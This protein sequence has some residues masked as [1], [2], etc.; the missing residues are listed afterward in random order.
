SKFMMLLSISSHPGTSSVTKIELIRKVFEERPWMPLSAAS[1]LPMEKTVVTQRQ[2]LSAP[3]SP[4]HCPAQ[5]PRLL[6]HSRHP[7]VVQFFLHVVQPNFYYPKRQTLDTT[8]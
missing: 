8:T 6:Q 2:T 3:P 7:R 1:S 5:P 4:P